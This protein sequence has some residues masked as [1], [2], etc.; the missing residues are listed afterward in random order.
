VTTGT[1][2]THYFTAT[3]TYYVEANDGTCPSTRTAVTAT[4][5]TNPNINIGPPAISINQGQSIVLD[6]GAGFAN[7]DWSTGATTHSITVTLDGTYS[8]YVTDAHGCHGTDTIVVN[9]IPNGIAIN[10]LDHAVELYPN[11][12]SGEIN[13]KVNFTKHFDIV[14]TDVVGQ[15]LLSDTHRDNS[16]FNKTYDLSAFSRGIYFLRLN[17]GEGST[18]RSIIIQ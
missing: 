6:A 10:E 13:V 1:A 2:F 18:T 12:T 16:L 14:I 4:I 7:Y 5:W 9:V 15:I 17:S 8:V 11:P 3:T